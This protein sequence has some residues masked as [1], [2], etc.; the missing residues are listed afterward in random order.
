MVGSCLQRLLV[1]SGGIFKPAKLPL[2]Q[3]KL[4]KRHGT[5]RG[6]PD[7]FAQGCFRVLQATLCGQQYAQVVGRAAEFRGCFHQLLELEFGLDCLTGIRLRHGAFV[8]CHQSC[9]GCG[10]GQRFII[11]GATTDLRTDSCSRGAQGPAKAVA[12]GSSVLP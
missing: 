8:L 3:S 5:S 6:A 2:H 10:S 12:S 11:G 1:R 4:G 9:R 7:G